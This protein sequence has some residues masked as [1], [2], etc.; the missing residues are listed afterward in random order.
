MKT[1]RMHL[2]ML[3][4]S[5]LVLILICSVVICFWGVFYGQAMI[6][7]QIVRNNEIKLERMT[8]HESK[9]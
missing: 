4:L 2:K 1:I 6:A 5:V 8:N 3:G 7:E 9:R